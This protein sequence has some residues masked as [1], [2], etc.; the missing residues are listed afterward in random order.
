MY[1]ALF[2]LLLSGHQHNPTRD[3]IYRSLVACCLATSVGSHR[4]GPCLSLLRVNF[5]L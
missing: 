1:A 2:A 5:R 4:Y 3:I